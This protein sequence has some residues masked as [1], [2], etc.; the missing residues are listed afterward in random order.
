MNSNFHPL[1]WRIELPN[2]LSEELSVDGFVRSSLIHEYIHYLQFLISTFGRVILIDFIR[3]IILGGLHKYYYPKE[4][5][6][7]YQQ[8]DLMK[9][10]QSSKPS[11]FENSEAQQNLITLYY[12]IEA[13]MNVEPEAI[14]STS[15]K[16]IYKRLKTNH[17]NQESIDTSMLEDFP[18][19]VIKHNNGTYIIALTDR[20]F[21]D[22]MARQIQRNYLYFSVNDTSYVDKLQGNLSEQVYLCIWKLIK[23]LSKKNLDSRIVTILMCQLSLMCGNPGR[24]FIRMYNILKENDFSNIHDFVKAIGRN[25]KI[26]ETFDNPPIQKILDELLLKYGTAFRITENYKL[27]TFIGPI[28]RA[29]NM[30]MED[31]LYFANVLLNWNEFMKWIKLL[32][33][34]PINLKDGEISSL[35]GVQLGSSW[36]EYLRLGVKLLLPNNLQF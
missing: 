13:M 29:S 31:P 7:R 32:G 14:K 26:M 1:N 12:D 6:D 21:L 3:N 10:L 35:N 23:E 24:S 18:Y 25:E 15:K 28:V 4:V 22:N 16:F 20:V 11:D 36:Y 17:P 5:P 8:I 2:F 27:K 34:P 30:V 19:I 9:Q 33:C